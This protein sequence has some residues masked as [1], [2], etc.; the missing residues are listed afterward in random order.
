[1]VIPALKD[2]RNRVM[3]DMMMV[4][5]LSCKSKLTG[6]MTA[7]YVAD[8]LTSI[9]VK[10]IYFNNTVNDSIWFLNL[11]IIFKRQIIH[12]NVFNFVQCSSQLSYV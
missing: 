3:Y 10:I 1:M 5:S 9:Y 11:N 2:F 8:L 7:V 12:C 6:I 4:N